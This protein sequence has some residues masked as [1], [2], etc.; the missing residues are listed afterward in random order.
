MTIL[1]GWSLRW[2]LL[3]QGEVGDA[4][5]RGVIA[6]GHLVAAVAI[7]INA[8]SV[9]G[10]SFIGLLEHQQEY[11]VSE[12]ESARP[13]NRGDFVGAHAGLLLPERVGDALRFGN[14][15]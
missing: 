15:A 9:V 2:K 3:L 8:R 10:L 4:G 1:V 5:D 6:D 12:F 13:E 7:H 14:C 11:G